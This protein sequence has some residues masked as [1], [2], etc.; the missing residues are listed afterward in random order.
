MKFSAFITIGILY[1]GYA[2]ATGNQLVMNELKCNN[3]KSGSVVNSKLSSEVVMY[4]DGSD[5]IYN[6]KTIYEMNQI[7]NYKF[8]NEILI[9]NSV[10]EYIYTPIAVKNRKLVNFV[11]VDS[12]DRN[13]IEVD[14]S[15]DKDP[16]YKG[17][18]YKT[19]LNQ[20]KYYSVWPIQIPCKDG[21]IKKIWKKKNK[22]SQNEFK[23]YNLHFVKYNNKN[24]ILFLPPDYLITLSIKD[25]W[26]ETKICDI[27]KKMKIEKVERMIEILI[28]DEMNLYHFSSSKGYT[29]DFDYTKWRSRSI[30]IDSKKEK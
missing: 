28:D 20:S 7:E 6:K 18:F 8:Q 12:L 11:Y 13:T 22:I 24:N 23:S 30:S 10:P 26:C 15:K 4:S 9:K 27:E 29:P 2:Y 16:K 3:M 5:S 19:I 14:P 1:A 21:K 25:N 17:V